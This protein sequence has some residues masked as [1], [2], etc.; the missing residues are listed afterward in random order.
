MQGEHMHVFHIYLKEIC[1]TKT[2][3]VTFS[4]DGCTR[5]SQSTNVYLLIPSYIILHSF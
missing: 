2:T 4:Q 5:G 3:E 1:I